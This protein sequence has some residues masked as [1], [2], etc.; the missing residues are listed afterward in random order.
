MLKR[1][2]LTLILLAPLSALG[3]YTT[4]SATVSDTNGIPYAGGT[5]NAT[6]PAGEYFASTGVQPPSSASAKLSSTGSFTLQLADNTKLLPI[7]SQWTFNVCYSDGVTCFASAITIS[8][9]SQSISSTL[10]AA[11]AP[12]TTAFNINVIQGGTLLQQNVRNINFASGC[13]WN[14]TALRIDCTFGSGGGNVS[15][16]GT[17]TSGQIAQFVTA[18]TITGISTTGSGNAVLAN[19]P[20]LITPNIGAA[21]GTSLTLSGLG[22]GGT[23]CLHAS[24]TGVISTAA[25]DC[26]SGGGGGPT[27]QTNGVNNG[28]QALLNFITSS[29]NAVGLTATPINSVGT[30]TFEITGGSYTGN[31]TTASKWATPRALAGNNVDGSAAVAFANKFIVQGTT[32]AGLSGAQFLGALGT[33]IIKNTTATG[34]LSIAVAGDFPTLNQS[35]T[36]TAANL[37]GTP[38]LPNGTTAT[39]Q[40]VGDNTTKLATDAFVLANAITNPM[41]TIGDMIGGGASGAPARIVGGKTGQSIF[42]TNAAT[43]AFASPGISDGNGGAAVTTTPYPIQCDSSTAL[44]DRST[45]LRFQTGASVITAPDHTA[46][47]CANNMAFTLI[48]DNAGTLTVNRGGTD[49]FSVFTGSTATDGAT[50][51]TLSNGQY[52]TLNNGAGGVWEVRIVSG[53]AGANTALSNLASVAINLALSPGTDATISLDD[54]T[55]RYINAWLSGVFGWTNGSGTADTGLSRGAAGVIAAGNGT[56]ADTS[57]Q[58]QATSFLAK[59]STAGF[60]DFPQGSTSASTAPCNTANSWCI[61]APTA[62]TAGVETMVGVHAQ[63]IPFGVGSSAALQDGISGDSNHSTTVTIGSG[64]S[65]GTTTLCSSG[66]CPAGVYKLSAY[67]DVTTACTTTGTYFA[68]VT[69]TDDVGSKTIVLPLAGTGTTLTLLGPAAFTD[70]ISL[71]STSNFAQGDFTFRSSGAAAISYSTTAGACGTG[72]PAVGKMYLSVVPLQ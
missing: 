13:T 3:Q 26:G 22:G 42:A 61:Q 71:A 54:L 72:G 67:I 36:G 34:V 57:A 30:Q 46:T 19:T 7:N 70:S 48:D 51:F 39:T 28:S 44:I 40:T 56:A 63:G 14:S 66:N 65:I 16:S 6:L 27:L 29:T 11:S 1:L 69:Y 41:T 24:N 25:A 9:S 52:A 35:T 59:G 17:P 32:D 58:L 53:G 12:I 68:S 20:T 15:N 62:V 18:T 2:L 49:T 55:H 60:I 33:G 8:G 50:S 10:T 21:T 47:G 23:L 64:T 38:A 37:S 43:P 31:A 5:V 45:T 4:V